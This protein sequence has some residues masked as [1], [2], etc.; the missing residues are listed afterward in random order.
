LLTSKQTPGVVF[1]PQVHRAL[2][3]GIN[4]IVGAVRPTLGPV[5]G[6]VVIDHVNKA[7]TLPEYL[8]D[9]GLI[10]RRI[11]EL[12][13][14][15][16]DMGAMLARS[17]IVSQYEEVGDG[18]ATAAVLLEAIF[19]AGVRYISAGGNAMQLRRHLE[20]TIPVIFETLD[21]MVTRLEGQQAFTRLAS[22]LCYNATM[23]QLL[24]E[25]FD[26]V[27]E[28]GQL[29][30]REAYG[31]ELRL[32]YVA[33]TYYESG[34]ISRAI[35]P[36][37][38]MTRIEFENP[39]FF[40]CDFTIENRRDLYP[41][42]QTAYQAGFKNLVIVLR[43]LS[44]QGVSLLATNNRMD[45]LT[46]IA[47]K[48]PGLNETDRNAT[49]EDLSILTGAVPI[50]EAT[51]AS[52]EQVTPAHFGQVRR[53]WADLRAFGIV[54]GKGNPRHIREH[55]HRLKARYQ[56]ITDSSDRDRERTR[57]RIGKL[58]GGSVTLWVGG[59]TEPEIQASKSLADRSAMAMRTALENGVVPGGGITLLNVREVL[60]QKSIDAQDTDERAA[61]HM[62]IEALAA[63]ART[64]YQNARHDPSE[65]MA[66]LSH[67]N[68]NQGFDVLTGCI[69]D[70]YEMGILDSVSVLKSCLKHAIH[71]A[72]L[73]LTT[74]TF[75]HVRHLQMVKNP[76]G[77]SD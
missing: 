40:I 77:T 72:A 10:A 74:D 27:G 28:H 51:G 7:E 12:P 47:L 4:K 75:V 41:V 16:E 17:M 13:D 58:L 5:A 43:D 56:S 15:N 70:V 69:V 62:L 45:T 67:A 6:G 19:N 42:L 37:E 34:L 54:G 21:A 63:P 53:I 64:I 57:K 8:D 2:Q 25:A 35:L 61:Y 11:I 65:V 33:G 60:R 3:Q 73:A 1:Q 76:D 49:L 22:T 52:L 50:L 68:G 71:T 26:L 29:E 55:I 46:S 39:A 14:R 32:E 59:F 9:G 24:G 66:K 23:A 48:L 36:N 31:R 18:T 30:I 38:A 20:A 44:E